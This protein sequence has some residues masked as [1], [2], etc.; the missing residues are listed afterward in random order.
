MTDKTPQTDLDKALY[1]ADEADKIT[2]RHF[3]SVNLRVD[4]KP[5]KTPV[6]E[7][8]L[9]TEKRL[10]Q[11]IH[12]EFGDNFIGEEG[13]RDTAKGRRWVVDP[14]DGTEPFIRGIP[15]AANML[16]LIDN[17]QP[18]MGIIHNFC[19]GDYYLAIKGRGATC[20][21]HAIH[22]SKRPL[23]GAFISVG[24]PKLDRHDAA[25]GLID[26]LR[27]KLGRSGG[28]FNVGATGYTL[29]AVASGAIEGRI[30]V[31]GRSK[32]WDYAPGTLLIQEAG[33]RVANI[34]VDTYDYR[35]VDL[36]A[37]NNVIFDELMQFAVDMRSPRTSK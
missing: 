5:D 36:V 31:A 15:T 28:I 33:G 12:E 19:L 30:V 27:P 18:I 7:A 23:D 8:D 14:I 29:T 26:Q 11:I 34:G 6:T 22:V 13:T 25:F 24:N 20:N 16:A 17:G 32:P 4:T 2:K 37:T 10:S 3:R 9:E 21:G 1:L 35:D